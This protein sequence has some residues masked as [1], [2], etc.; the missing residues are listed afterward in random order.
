MMPI[1]D[2]PTS[3]VVASRGTVQITVIPSVFAVF[4]NT[5]FSRQDKLTH[6]TREPAENAGNI[7]TGRM[8]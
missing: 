8:R 2:L 1:M 3:K 7:Q 4:K 6:S 5:G